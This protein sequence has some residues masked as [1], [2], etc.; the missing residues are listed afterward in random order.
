MQRVPFRILA[1]FLAIVSVAWL[2]A[3]AQLAAASSTVPD[4]DRAA[5]T[6]PYATQA[7]Y[8]WGAGFFVNPTPPEDAAR[9]LR[10]A[11]ALQEVAL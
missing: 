5:Q 8:D 4:T 7:G 1:V 10:E 9:F 6:G 2:L 3:P 11:L